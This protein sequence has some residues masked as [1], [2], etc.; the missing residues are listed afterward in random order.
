M[1]S[2]TDIGRYKFANLEEVLEICPG[3][4]QEH[5]T[6]AKKI[7]LERQEEIADTLKN[8]KQRK[9]KENLREDNDSLEL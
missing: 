9:V 3:L 8:F 2:L 4:S 5:K 1:D 7:F 6:F